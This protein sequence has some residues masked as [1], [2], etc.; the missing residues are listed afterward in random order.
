MAASYDVIEE[1][2]SI[3]KAVD[4]LLLGEGSQ[5]LCSSLRLQLKQWR[6][7]ET[8]IEGVE[9][10][11]HDKK[12]LSFDMLL[13]VHKQL[14]SHCL[15]EYK[16]VHICDLL[17]GSSIVFPRDNPPAKN[18]ELVARLDKIRASIENNDYQ[19]MVGNVE[20]QAKKQMHNAENLRIDLQ[21]THRQLWVV[22]NFFLTVIGSFVFG[23][24]A[25][26]FAGMS[27]T[28]CTLTGFTFAMAVFLADL[29][30]IAKNA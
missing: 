26:Y 10:N 6:Q 13:K 19:K 27:T 3:Q 23:F 24:Y 14:K 7:S 25:A 5:D 11:A 28:G 1:T 29:Y 12:L 17:D 4:H 2:E 9:K 21:A 20:I 16:S 22:V 18:P 30:F 15:P 8:G